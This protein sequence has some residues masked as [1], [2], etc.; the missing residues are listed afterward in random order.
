VGYLIH[1]GYTS[2]FGILVQGVVVVLCIRPA[3][4]CQSLMI[5]L[6][7]AISQHHICHRRAQ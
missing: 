3:A 5:Y 1:V 2:G 4:H 6:T 7:C